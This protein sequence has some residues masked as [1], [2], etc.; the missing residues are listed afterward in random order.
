MTKT[1]VH[2]IDSS[3]KVV[4]V[5]ENAGGVTITLNDNSL[6]A[7]FLPDKETKRLGDRLTKEEQNRYAK[8]KKE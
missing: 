7:V 5:I 8:D 4:A 2:Y 6:T 3:R 1:K